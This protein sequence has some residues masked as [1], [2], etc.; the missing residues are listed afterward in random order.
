VG[1]ANR[2]RRLQGEEQKPGWAWE[3]M[4]QEGPVHLSILR[5]T[6]GD[7]TFLTYTGLGSV[8]PD[9]N[10]AGVVSDEMTQQAINIMAPLTSGGLM[11]VEIKSAGGAERRVRD[12][13]NAVPD[14]GIVVF[15][16]PDDDACAAATR[17]I[18]SGEKMA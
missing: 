17:V 10:R 16:S 2:R 9:G 8:P 15:V 14:D 18:L 11:M 4:L 1:E 5:V 3:L 6:L 12:A 7:K 13:F